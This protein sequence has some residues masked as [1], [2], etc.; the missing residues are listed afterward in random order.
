MVEWAALFWVPSILVTDGGT[1][2]DCSLISVLTRRFRSRHHIT[3]AHSPWANGIIERVNRE[4]IRLWKV[5]ISEVGLSQQ[6]WA[7]L[8]P[9]VQA[10]LNRSPSAVLGLSPAEVQFARKPRHPLDTIAFSKLDD[11]TR[12]ALENVDWTTQARDYF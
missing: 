12:R 7:T 4:L 9:L 10:I 11:E 5:L 1:H 8:R 6:E 3:T 2:F